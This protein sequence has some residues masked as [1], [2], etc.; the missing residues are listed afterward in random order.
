M[1]YE[2]P[3]SFD[4]DGKE[5]H[6]TNKGDYRMVL[7]CFNA[8]EDV[9]LSKQERLWTA[10]I[11]FFEE[12]NSLEDIGKIKDLKR[13]VENMY[14]F[15]NCGQSESPGMNTNYK[16]VDWEQDSHLICSAVNDVAGKEIR[17]EPYIH[18]WT[19][20]GYYTAIGKCLLSTVIGIRY[21]I[22]RGKK[23][24]KYEQ[25]FRRENPNYFVWNSRTVEQKEADEYIKQL[26]NSNS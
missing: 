26:W 23:L 7:D 10:L 8:L 22:M 21:K 5:Y 18:W 4:I 20:M 14:F 1:M 12:L 9:D 15:F 3:T 6:I 16:L 19:F 24:E 2:L 17:T 13:L 25:D 11:I